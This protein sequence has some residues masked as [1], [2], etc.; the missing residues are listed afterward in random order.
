MYHGYLAIGPDD[1]FADPAGVQEIINTA[2][3]FSYVANAGIPWLEWCD[4]CEP[5]SVIVPGGPKFVSPIVDPAPWYDLDDPDSWGF[6]GVFGLDVEG[7]DS[8]TRQAEVSMGLRGMGVIGPSYLGPRTLTVRAGAVAADECSLQ[9]GLN[10]LRRQ[11]LS[12]SDPCGGDRLTF[13]ECCP[14]ICED[15]D[16]DV[17]ERCWIQNNYGE[18]HRGPTLCDTEY[19]PGSYDD[20][21]EGPPLGSEEFCSWPTLYRHLPTGPPTWTCCSDECVL[22]YVRQ[23]YNTRVTEGPTVLNHPSMSS[24]CF[25]EL[26]FVIVAADPIPHSLTVS[27]G[28]TRVMGGGDLIT[29]PTVVVTPTPDPWVTAA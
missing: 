9:Y 20:L 19:W 4:D 17:D 26:E 14:C 27:V 12:V 10:W 29:D 1:P 24:G 2:R 8:S 11:Y 25:M 22:P 15:A 13:F 28:A 18:L 3:C 7:A 5:A 21:I 23:F 16:P 6:F